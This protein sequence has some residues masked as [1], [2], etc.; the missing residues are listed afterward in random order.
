[1][2]ASAQSCGEVMRQ[3]AFDYVVVGAGS[4]GAVIAARLSEDPKTRVLL[5]EAGGPDNNLWI[6]VPLGVGKL[7]TNPKY[8]WQY[9]TQKGS[10]PADQAVYWP[11]GR[12]L[13]GSSS[14]NG[15]VFVRGSRNAWDAWRDL[16]NQGWGYEDVLPYFKRLEDRAGGD[17][18]YRGVGGPIAVSDV[19]HPSAVSDA[20][21]SACQAIGAPRLEDYNGPDNAG[22]APLQLSVRNGRRCSTSV[23]YLRPAMQ[24]GNLTVLTHATV[25]Q[26]RFDGTRC[27][28]VDYVRDGHR[29]SV[30]ATREVILCAG[31]I[32]S[33]A[34]LERS[35][36]GH[37]DVLAKAGIAPRLERAEVGENLQDHLQ[38]RMSFEITGERT[39][40]DIM[41]KPLL[42]ALEGLQYLLRRRGLLATS[43]V[44]AHA[45]MRACADS[46]HADTK[47]QLALMSGRDRYSAGGGGLDQCPGMTL[48]A[49]QIRPQSRGSVHVGSTDPSAAPTIVANYLQ[50]DADRRLTVA[51][52]RLIRTIAAQPQL[53]RLIKRELLPGKDLS[54]DEQLLAYAGATGQTSWHPI[55]TCR[56]GSDPGAVVD[57][58]LR[59]RGLDALRVADASIMPTMVSTNTNAPCIMIGEKAA[60]LV[61]AANR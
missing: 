2:D 32:E 31:S 36:I 53:S 9:F 30:H 55:G 13:G 1:M 6:H 48:G 21:V 56:M 47:V 46:D 3:D 42:G 15:M 35:G 27:V 20:F 19:A 51:A 5:L 58:E 10:A 18:A 12:M 52:L 24:R 41:N 49:F 26:L 50:T 34:I 7:L 44:T 33:P 14:V 8:V 37:P 22:V 23:G 29:V 57:P 54:S 39:V 11:K 61:M 17:P 40:N 59:V 45:I 16:G 28:G 25:D 38:V 60:D 4:A 43:T